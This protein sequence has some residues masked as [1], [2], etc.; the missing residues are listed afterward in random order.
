LAPKGMEPSGTLYGDLF[1]I[2]SLQFILHP[3][4]LFLL[5]FV[6]QVEAKGRGTLTASLVHADYGR[7]LLATQTFPTLPFSIP[8]RVCIPFT[9][10]CV[11][12]PLA[13]GFAAIVEACIGISSCW[14]M[15]GNAVQRRKCLLPGCAAAV[16]TLVLWRQ[17]DVQ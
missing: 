9:S 6:L 4:F 2:T 16:S 7:N 14:P 10:N 5:V 13:I 8:R 17:M 3:L 11:P 15:K 12:S 1:S